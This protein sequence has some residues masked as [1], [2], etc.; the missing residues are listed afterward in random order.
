MGWR[1]EKGRD[2]EVNAIFSKVGLGGEH[3]FP[4]LNRTVIMVFQLKA[5]PLH[6]QREE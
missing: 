6:H 4:P 5:M 1:G 2:P 3:A